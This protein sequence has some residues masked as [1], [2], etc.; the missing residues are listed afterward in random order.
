MFNFVSFTLIAQQRG[1][2][3]TLD[4]EGRKISF[5]SKIKVTA[6]IT[7]TKNGSGHVHYTISVPGKTTTGGRYFRWK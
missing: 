3:E 4:V 1:V 5:M 6:K 2:T 7:A